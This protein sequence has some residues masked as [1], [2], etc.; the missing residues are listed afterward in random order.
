MEL[1]EFVLDRKWTIF[2]FRNTSDREMN[3]SHIWTHIQRARNRMMSTMECNE[4]FS[5]P[6]CSY[7]IS[8]VDDFVPFE[9]QVVDRY[10]GSAIIRV[11]ASIW[12]VIVDK[13][14]SIYFI[15][16][17]N[18]YKT[19]FRMQPPWTATSLSTLWLWMLYDATMKPRG[20]NRKFFIFKL[21]NC[22][23]FLTYA[24]QT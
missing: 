10:S 23:D 4:L 9:V 21:Y 22:V 24:L 16:T 15:P 14:S 8:S 17:K 20:V 2:A 3:P 19:H 13:M 18:S 12:Y 1:N 6:V 11:K 7:A 5:G